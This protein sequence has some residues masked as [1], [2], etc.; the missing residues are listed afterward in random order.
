MSI[1][2]ARAANTATRVVANNAEEPEDLNTMLKKSKAKRCDPA[3]SGPPV[4]MH[5][6]TSFG[7][8]P[9]AIAKANKV[10]KHSSVYF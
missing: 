3:I 10:L 2:R 5:P 4:I 9:Q 8:M 7:H 6:N 1:I